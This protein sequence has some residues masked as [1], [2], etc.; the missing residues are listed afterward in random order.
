MIA[1]FDEHVFSIHEDQF[2]RVVSHYQYTGYR[3]EDTHKHCE[4]EDM[5]V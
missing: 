4:S 1:L 2:G 5:Q 3:D